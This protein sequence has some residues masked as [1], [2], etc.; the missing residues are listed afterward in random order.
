MPEFG[1][2]LSLVTGDR[3]LWT[4]SEAYSTLQVSYPHRNLTATP[5]VTTVFQ[6]FALHNIKIIRIPAFP[7]YAMGHL[8]GASGDSRISCSSSFR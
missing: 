5:D 1:S 3:D 8:V 4:W 7:L 2:L 6:L